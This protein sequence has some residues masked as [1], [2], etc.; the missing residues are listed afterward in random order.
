MEEMY[1]DALEV[2]QSGEFGVTQDTYFGYDDPEDFNKLCA[3]GLGAAWLKNNKDKVKG[4]PFAPDF[5]D[6]EGYCS[7]QYNI[8]ISDCVDFLHGFD[9][10]NSSL[11]DIKNFNAYNLG[12]QLFNTVN[13]D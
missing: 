5:E 12:K 11:I 13:K 2:F 7:K 3:C 9:G 4:Y 10:E 1:K 8:S 6:I